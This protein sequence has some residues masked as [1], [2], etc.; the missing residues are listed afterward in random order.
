VDLIQ[1]VRTSKRTGYRLVRGTVGWVLGNVTPKPSPPPDSDDPPDLSSA[2]F[3]PDFLWGVATASHQVEGG[4]EDN[5]WHVF[6]SSK[7]IRERVRKLTSLVGRAVE[8][9][10]AGVA[11]RH[12]DLDV[13]REDLDRA[14]LLGMNAYRFSLEW[15]RIQPRPPSTSSPSDEDFDQGAIDYYLQALHEMRARGLE[16]ILTIN[17]MTLP[18]WVLTPSRGNSVLQHVGL[19]TAVP[20][21]GFEDSLMGWENADTVEAFV[22]F[23]DYIVPKYKH[24]VDYWITINE[25]VG[26]MVGVGFI[27]GIWPPGFNLGGAFPAPTLRERTRA[28]NAYFNL[29]K[30]H[31]LA[32]DKIKQLDDSDAD[33]DGRDSLV[34]FA[35]AMMHPQVADTPDPL[36]AHAEATKQFDYFYNHHFLESVIGN[37]DDLAASSVDVAIAH[38][39]KDREGVPANDFFGIGGSVLWRPRLD[40]VGVNYYRRVHVSWDPVVELAVGFTGGRFEN[41]QTATQNPP[42][43]LN[44][45][46]WEIYPKGIY[47]IMRSIHDRYRLPILI[48]ENGMADAFGGNRPANTVA[49]LQQTL[50]A[51]DDGVDVIGYI[52][53]SLLDN[54][55]WHEHYRD[56]ARFGLFQVDR[57]SATPSEPTRQDRHMTEGAL[58]LQYVVADGGLTEAVQCFGTITPT[59]STTQPPS[60]LRAAIFEGAHDDGT[61]FS[62]YIRR[63]PDRPAGAA[64]W[65]GMVFLVDARLWLRLDAISW[66]DPTRK[67]EFSHPAATGGPHLDYEGT[68]LNGTLSGTVTQGT[69][70]Q[71][72]QAARLSP[73]GLWQGD[74]PF[75]T[76][77]LMRLE[78]DF[79]GWSGKVLDPG[80]RERWRPIPEISWDG[81][82]LT[83]G[84]LHVGRVVGTI[85]QDTLTGTLKRD[86]NG[87]ITTI[88]Y[89]A[90]RLPSGMPF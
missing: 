83:F 73:L 25:P 67:L 14:K 31:V 58:A 52:H 65:I 54:W 84:D 36:G 47:A 55:E 82:M 35:H 20:D 12:G 41:D 49:H 30:A 32:F 19:P 16:P 21:G 87:R 34:G 56:E 45:L 70:Q 78:G 60:V 79:G 48:T 69:T 33:G 42:S 61:T 89:Q 5:D 76:F 37:V 51:L 23:V 22:D 15:S 81:R 17:H 80:P 71:S 62:V 13:L 27:A 38:D 72:W 53:W 9:Q 68:E 63:L 40:F 44:D 90:T 10:P 86:R 28:E 18:Q 4:I 6:S 2:R 1:C 50:R 88:P 85:Q 3:P 77:L 59:G 11:V 26:S 66:D 43:V 39:P 46:G 7:A 64:R 57:N 24:L 8:L 75:E 29:I 74:S